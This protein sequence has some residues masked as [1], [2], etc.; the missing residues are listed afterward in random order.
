MEKQIDKGLIINNQMLKE[1][2]Q[3]LLKKIEELEKVV[4][5]DNFNQKE[6]LYLL[7]KKDIEYSEQLKN[8]QNVNDLLTSSIDMIKILKEGGNSL[9]DA[10]TKIGGVEVF[11][12]LCNFILID[13]IDKRD[14]LRQ[15]NIDVLE[16]FIFLSEEFTKYYSL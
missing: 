13:N 8:L 12:K 7:K 15:E 9:I 3:I 2:N 6:E 5:D 4:V 16:K 11:F 14:S 10:I 1:Q